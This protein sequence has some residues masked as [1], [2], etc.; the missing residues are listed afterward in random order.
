MNLAAIT[1]EP[2][3]RSRVSR[4]N[5]KLSRFVN[6]ALPLPRKEALAL[7]YLV[8]SFAVPLKILT[9][10]SVTLTSL[11]KLQ[12]TFQFEE[13]FFTGNQQELSLRQLAI[14]AF[15]AAINQTGV[16][17]N[18]GSQGL[19]VVSKNSFP[20]LKANQLTPQYV[21][22]RMELLAEPIDLV[23]KA[24]CRALSMHAKPPENSTA[25]GQAVAFTK[26]LQIT[27]SDTNGKKLIKF[28]SKPIGGISKSSLILLFAQLDLKVLIGGKLKV[29]MLMD[30]NTQREYLYFEVEGSAGLGVG[31]GFSAGIEAEESSPYDLS[32]TTSSFNVSTEFELGPLVLSFKYVGKRPKMPDIKWG[33]I[34]KIPLFETNGDELL[35]LEG[36]T[37]TG[38]HVKK[39]NLSDRITNAM[40]T[41]KSNPDRKGVKGAAASLTYP[42]AEI[43]FGTVIVKCVLKPSASGKV[44]VALGPEY[45]FGYKKVLPMDMDF[46]WFEDAMYDLMQAYLPKFSSNKQPKLYGY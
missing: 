22:K 7:S 40:E 34:P 37:K 12:V 23:L 8:R 41:K 36:D 17:Q 16:W 45:K 2:M 38:E 1:V 18:G 39:G 46:G 27:A 9:K 5:G 21:L 25:Y 14:K 42:I 30:P 15:K 20:F 4:H 10:P 19:H 3:M 44:K 11:Q 26:Q 31:G 13:W 32:G 33:G 28:A 35:S 29:G 24:C 43:D 6:G